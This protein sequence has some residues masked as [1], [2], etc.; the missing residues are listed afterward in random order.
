MGVDGIG[1][2]AQSSGIGS[3]QMATVTALQGSTVAYA[4]PRHSLLKTQ[5]FPLADDSPRKI[6]P[7]SL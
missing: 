4:L 5:P 6:F 1:L 3:H 7:V 2:S